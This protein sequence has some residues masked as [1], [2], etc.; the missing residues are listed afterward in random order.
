MKFNSTRKPHRLPYREVGECYL[1]FKGKLVAQDHK[2]YLM[3][4]GGGIDEGESPMVGTN[5]ELMEELGI[6][7]KR[8]LR[9][10]SEIHWDW[11]SK[12]ANNDKRKQR[13]M[14][15]RGEHVYSYFGEVESFIKA[16]S[17]E[18]D[19]W[20]GRKSMSLKTATIKLREFM[21][22]HNVS[23]NQYAYQMSKLNIVSVI[24]LLHCVD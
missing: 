7:L 17:T 16:T 22:K 11:D 10:I 1:L 3:L 24:S 14:R 2:H 19:A 8:P 9:L 23:S 5:R 6:R 13:F 4:P 21:K 20:K 12:W 18:G 15:F